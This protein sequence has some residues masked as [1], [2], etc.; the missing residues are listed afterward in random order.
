MQKLT[1]SVD[2]EVVDRAK[3]YAAERGTSVSR[4]VEN[5]LDALTRPKTELPPLDWSKAPILAQL[6]KDLARV[7]FG[8]DPRAEYRAHLLRKYR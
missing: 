8:D 7:R 6:R 4:L 1:L 3:A 2:G 5:Y